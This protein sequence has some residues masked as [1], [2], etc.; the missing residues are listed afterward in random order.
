MMNNSHKTRVDKS[1]LNTKYDELVMRNETLISEVTRL[2]GENRGL[3]K[4]WRYWVACQLNKPQ[5]TIPVIKKDACTQTD[6][7]LPRPNVQQEFQ[8]FADN[9]TL[10]ISRISRVS[11]DS[12]ASNASTSSARRMSINLSQRV[13]VEKEK[14]NEKENY[15]KP[16]SPI[17]SSTLL[18]SVLHTP[19]RA[20]PRRQSRTPISY[21]EPSLKVK[22][23][24]GFQ[25]FKTTEENEEKEN[26]KNTNKNE[27]TK[28]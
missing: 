25:F 15:N 26:K 27:E 20:F 1:G 6:L 18:L 21:A 2:R 13:V 10:D 4:K 5:N 9:P 28:K 23:R 22:V 7:E 3:E 8:D 11:T 17:S 19:P 24:K 14:E 16:I 12:T